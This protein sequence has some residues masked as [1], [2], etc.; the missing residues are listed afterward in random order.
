MANSSLYFAYALS[1]VEKLAHD[2]ALV[3][4]LVYD[5]VISGKLAKK[6]RNSKSK[7]R[8]VETV[9]S[10]RSAL[11][12]ALARLKIKR[13]VA[14]SEDLAE[15]QTIAMHSFEFTG[16]RESTLLWQRLRVFYR[17]SKNKG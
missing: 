1:F 6:G 7:G 14:N 15:F 4:A 16:M 12:A 9:L 5:A 11:C 13:G 2:Y 17:R 8:W 3:L 10:N